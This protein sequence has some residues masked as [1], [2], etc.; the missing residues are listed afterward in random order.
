MDHPKNT[1]DQ[2]KKPNADGQNSR[3]GKVSE[4]KKVIIPRQHEEDR[5]Q[6]KI[7]TKSNVTDNDSS[8]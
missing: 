2:K 6:G 1:P 4:S 3:R 8:L 7:R 5:G